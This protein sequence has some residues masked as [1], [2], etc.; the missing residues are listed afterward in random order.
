MPVAVRLN[1]HVQKIWSEIPWWS[2]KV[3]TSYR[4]VCLVSLAMI[5]LMIIRKFYTA[6]AYFCKL[7]VRILDFD[8][9]YPCI[10]TT[11]LE[12]SKEAKKLG[13]DIGNKDWSFESDSYSQ[14][15]CYY[16]EQTLVSKKKNTAFF[17]TGGSIKQMVEK[18]RAIEDTMDSSGRKSI[19]KECL[20]AG[21]VNDIA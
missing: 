10:I 15:G 3:T 2:V 4:F 17:G 6:S 18:S 21:N 1:V 14:K 19:T 20:A 9:T 16:Y 8:P 5:W 12:C 11:P 7:F 13:L